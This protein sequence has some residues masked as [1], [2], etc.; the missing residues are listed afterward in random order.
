MP[1][2]PT[3]RDHAES[4]D[5]ADPLAPFADRFFRPECIAYLDGNSL[6]LLSV[7][8][9]RTVL[10]ALQSWKVYG[11][12]GWTGAA[13][14]WFTLGEHL[15]DQMAPLV[16]ATPESVVVTGGTTRCSGASCGCVAWRPGLATRRAS[17][18]RR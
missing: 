16:G 10:D 4:L 14:A 17:S 9:E 11:V 8:A 6:G 3:T 12:E 2:I 15:G 18:P 13:P 5:A 1:S 7:D